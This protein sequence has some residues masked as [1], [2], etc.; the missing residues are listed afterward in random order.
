MMKTLQ[1]EIAE[2]VVEEF[3]KDSSVVGIEICGSLARGEIRTDSDIDIEVISENIEKHQF[4][5]EF[6]QGVKVDIS[7]TP[8]GV[9]LESVET[10]PF[11]L[12]VS[13]LTKIVYDPKGI[14]KQIR[15]RLELYFDHH[16]EIVAFWEEKL[17]L[18]KAAK[19]KGEEQ[20][21]FRSVLDEAEMKFSE[22]KGISRAFFQR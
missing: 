6:R 3:K 5:E 21:G 14:L 8:L 22:G 9:I 13:L 15:D 11:L 17:S 18:M 10:H 2:E 1:E 19:M 7:T 20:E 4:M 12:Y 16:P